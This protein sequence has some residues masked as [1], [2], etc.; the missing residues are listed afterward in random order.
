[1]ALCYDEFINNILITR[2]RFNC[3]GYKER[4]HIIPKCMGGTN[5]E[6][7]L[8]D[9][10]AR[11]HFEA[12]RLLALENPKNSSL[13][14]AWWNMAHMTTNS[15]HERY[16]LTAEEYEEARTYFSKMQTGRFVS[17]ETRQKHRDIQTGYKFSEESKMKMSESHKNMSDETRKKLSNAKKRTET[18]QWFLD[19]GH[20]HRRKKV[21]CDGIIFNSV[22]DCAKY[23]GVTPNAITCILRRL[24]SYKKKLPQKW[25]DRNIAWYKEND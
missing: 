13:Q 3:Q 12:H 14:W 5:D 16:E 15:K 20:E 1:M 17:D 21:I 18:P 4:H 24:G 22:V 9:L 8:I 2:G 25:V 11:E 7:N 10:Y 6:N 19:M 23:C